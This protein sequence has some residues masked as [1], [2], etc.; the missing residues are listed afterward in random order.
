MNV[1]VIGGSGFIG[2]NLIEDLQQNE[3]YDIVNIDK[4]LSKTY[5]SITRI[6]DIRDK[7]KLGQVLDS[8][9]WCVMLAA[10]HRD[11]VTPTSLYFDVNVAGNKNIIDLLE[12]KKV[13]K[14]IFA[15]TVAIYGLNKPNP[16]EDFPAAP[17]NDYGESKWQAEGLLRSWYKRDADN[18][19]LIILRPTVVFGPGNRGN[20]YNLLRQIAS[21]K[22]LMVG[23]GNN[24]KSMA[25]VK[26]ITGFMKYCIEKD[27][28]GYHVFNYADKP[29][30]TM[31]DLV[32]ISEDSLKQ[33]LPSI[34]IPYFLGYL[35]GLFFDTLA[36]LTGR[37]YA[38]SAIRVKKFCANT[39]YMNKRVVESGYVPVA[40]LQDGL[41]T[42]IQAIEIEARE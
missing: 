41:A 6:A 22:F 31:N 27:M 26:N 2:T 4:A 3:R 10:E 20:V 25:Y 29:D 19:S 37:K 12:K 28:R 15:S 23:K 8:N 35:G 11:D 16:D 42:T 14:I 32:K 33:S 21:R 9:D 34:R 13:Q 7:E 38:V 17:F 1:V 18:R 5:P 24:E 40:S 39:Q 36:K 30:L